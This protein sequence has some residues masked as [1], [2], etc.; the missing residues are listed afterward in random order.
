MTAATANN[1]E[2]IGASLNLVA[3][4]TPARAVAA[5]ANTPY[6]AIRIRPGPYLVAAGSV[7]SG[8]PQVVQSQLE[9][10]DHQ[11][12]DGQ[13]P[14]APSAAFRQRPERADRQHDQR[15]DQVPDEERPGHVP[16]GAGDLHD[17]HDQLD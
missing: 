9:D 15:S 16:I 8:R 7:T 13:R 4:C 1:R 5:S 17:A 11:A 6:T 3:I 12:G 2:A 14:G 10:R